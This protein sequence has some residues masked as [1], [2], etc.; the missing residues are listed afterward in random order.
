MTAWC[1]VKGLNDKIREFEAIIDF[2]YSYSL[3]LRQDATD[4]GYSEASYRHS[5][6]HELRPDRAPLVLTSRGIERTILVDLKEV[7][8]GNLAAKNV[9]AVVLEYDLPPMVPVD[10]ILGQTFLKNFKLGLDPRSCTLSLS[11]RWI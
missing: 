3:M 2:N 1:R 6:W 11:R 5:G 4:L 7:S 9:R 10:M 8:V